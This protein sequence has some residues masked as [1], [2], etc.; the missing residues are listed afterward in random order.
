M[1]QDATSTFISV[2]LAEVNF[3]TQVLEE[4]TTANECCWA[5]LT[6][7]LVIETAM[8]VGPFLDL[9]AHG[10]LMARGTNAI[11]H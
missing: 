9:L 3:S 6:C 10:A 2:L 11:M 1:G 5:I 7:L 4:I 8:E